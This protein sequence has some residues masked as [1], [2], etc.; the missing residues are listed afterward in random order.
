V[1]VGAG[2]DVA[3]VNPGGVAGVVEAGQYEGGSGKFKL[4]TDCWSSFT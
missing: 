2:T 4:H 1:A 3:G